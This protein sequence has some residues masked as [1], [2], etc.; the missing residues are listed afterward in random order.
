MMLHQ[1]HMTHLAQSSISQWSELRHLLL[2]SLLD[3][4]WEYNFR[5]CGGIGQFSD[6]NS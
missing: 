2:V 6:K 5:Y 4:P 1:L 3:M